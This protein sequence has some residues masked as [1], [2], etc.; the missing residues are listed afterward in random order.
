[1][2]SRNK[3]AEKK[4]RRMYLIVRQ[5]SEKRRVRDRDKGREEEG[6]G[7][8]IRGDLSYGGT[9]KKDFLKQGFVLK[10]VDGNGSAARLSCR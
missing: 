3:R 6:N 8:K 4:E 1:M 7:V 2:I 5:M 10:R 9:M